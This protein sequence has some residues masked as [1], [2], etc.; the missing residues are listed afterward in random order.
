[1]IVALISLGAARETAKPRCTAGSGLGTIQLQIQSD[2]YSI[3]T[4]YNYDYSLLDR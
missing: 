4:H 2:K 1:M 3:T